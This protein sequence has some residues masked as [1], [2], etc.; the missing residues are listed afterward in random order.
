MAESFKFHP[1]LL[2][3]FREEAGFDLRRDLMLAANWG[4]TSHNTF[5][6]PGRRNGVDDSDFFC[7]LSSKGGPWRIQ[8]GQWD[9]HVMSISTY[10]ERAQQDPNVLGV[11]WGRDEDRL[12]KVPAIKPLFENRDAFTSQK[13]LTALHENAQQLGSLDPKSVY[14]GFLG[15]ARGKLYAR[16]GF[17]THG[18]GQLFRALKMTIEFAST[19]ELT[20]YREDDADLIKAIKRGYFQIPEVLAMVKRLTPM[21]AE[22]VNTNTLPPEPDQEQINQ[23]L[24]GD[25]T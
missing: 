9:L 16:I 2:D 6:K 14:E 11:L 25:T 17:D 7:I 13:V 24:T 12:V 1:H 20:V 18:A 21:A 5:I 15:E 19:G 3:A 4:S 23:L 10:I 22:A 8:L